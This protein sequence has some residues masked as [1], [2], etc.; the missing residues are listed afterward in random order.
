MRMAACS[1][2]STCA[3]LIPA[4]IFFQSPAST[5]RALLLD[6]CGQAWRS[7]NGVQTGDVG[8]GLA[9]RR[10]HGDII[11]RGD[12][13]G[14]APLAQT[15]RSRRAYAPHDSVVGHRPGPP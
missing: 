1:S 5:M 15:T 2:F 14:S 10:R 4:T 12:V 6:H 3:S 7:M 11:D 9:L 13:V 8:D